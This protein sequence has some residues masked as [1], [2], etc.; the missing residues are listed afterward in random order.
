MKAIDKGKKRAICIYH[1]RAGKDVT[2][3][4]ILIK[5]AVEKVGV[6]YYLLP[7]YAQAKRIIW[8][9][10]TNDGMKFIDY[11]PKEIISSKNGT[12]LKIVLING[13]VIQLIGTDNYDSIRGTNPVGCVFSE[14]AFQNPMAWDVVKP[15]LKL[16]GGWA[17]FNTTPQGEN[18]AYDMFEM[19]KSNDNWFTELLNI[20]DTKLLNLDDIQAERREGMPEEM[21]QQEYYCSFGAGLIGAYYANHLNEARDAGRICSFPVEQ[22]VDVHTVWDLGVNDT[23]AIWFFQ[24]VGKEIRIVD[25]FE[26]SGEGLGYYLEELKKRNYSYG[27]HYFPH[28]LKVREFTHG[29][30][31]EDVLRNDYGIRNYEVLPKL[32]IMDGINAVRKILPYCWFNDTK[33]KDGLRALKAY[34]KEYDEKH[35]VYRNRPLH[36]WA[37]NYADSFRYLSQ[38]ADIEKKKKKKIVTRQKVNPLTGKPIL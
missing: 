36:N 10:I 37:S 21:I 26:D 7:T 34:Q 8:D 2:L 35:K 13:S 28:D 33:T 24:R 14:Y 4:N 9:G 6:Y 15:I 32:S 19:A 3:W 31:R 5:K 20:N 16:N 30:S 17:V 29:K 22:A 23:T 27:T 18:H 38:V 25:C 12:E 11:I 1:R